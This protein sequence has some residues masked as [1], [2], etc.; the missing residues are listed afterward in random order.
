MTK[1]AKAILEKIAVG[2]SAIGPGPV[3]LRT[4]LNKIVVGA[5]ARQRY[6]A[7]RIFGKGKINKRLKK[8]NIEEMMDN[9]VVVEK[10]IQFIKKQGPRYW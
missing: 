10:A 5:K 1:K 4:L 8:M 6:E 9:P 3:S 7:K 2:R